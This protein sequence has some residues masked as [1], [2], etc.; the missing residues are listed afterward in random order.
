M[1]I[2]I[3]TS[4]IFY[5]EISDGSHHFTSFR[6]GGFLFKAGYGQIPQAIPGRPPVLLHGTGSFPYPWLQG[7]LSLSIFYITCPHSLS[8]IHCRIRSPSCLRLMAPEI[9]SSLLTTVPSLERRKEY[10]KNP[11]SLS[12]GVGA[13]RTAIFSS[14]SLS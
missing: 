6:S 11:A 2:I 14:A 5:S 12:S 13:E 7:F 10:R 9:S 1:K 3:F 8:H 4:N